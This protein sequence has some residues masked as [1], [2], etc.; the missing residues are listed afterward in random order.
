MPASSAAVEQ[1]YAYVWVIARQLQF[2]RVKIDTRLILDASKSSLHIKS[3]AMTPAMVLNMYPCRRAAAVELA[4]AEEER[5]ISHV[6]IT[7]HEHE[8]NGLISNQE[9]YSYECIPGRYVTQI[10]AVHLKPIVV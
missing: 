6:V 3:P 4:A 9:L 8:Y 10:D 5:Q 2:N 7:N 1:T